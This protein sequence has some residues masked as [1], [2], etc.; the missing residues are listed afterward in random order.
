MSDSGILTEEYVY[1]VAPDGQAVKAAQALLGGEAFD[2][3][4]SADGGRDLRAVCRG[5]APQPYSVHVN[6]ADPNNLRTGCDCSSRK[7]PCKHALALL[8]L[9]INSPHRFERDD[10][11]TAG[12]RSRD[13]EPLTSAAPRK[14]SAEGTA[15]PANLDESL[16]RAILAEPEDDGLR[17]IYADWLEENGRAERAEFIRVQMELARIG[18]A[19][20]RW[21]VLRADEKK[22]WSI[23]RESWLTGLPAHLRKRDIRFHKG[24]LEELAGPPKIWAGCWEELFARHP[25]YRIRVTGAVGRAEAGE[26]AVIPQMGKV[27]VL[28][29]AGGRL[30]EPSKNLAVLFGS[31]FLSG[32][33]RLDLSGGGLT[34]RESA[35]LAG[36][37]ALLG[38]RGLILADNEIGPKGAEWLADIPWREGLNELSLANNPIGDAG[39]KALAG[40][41]HLDALA[42]L[43]LSGVALGLRAKEL[44]R[45][46]FGTRVLLD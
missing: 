22:L 41:A 35:L 2:Q 1:R 34:W 6:L 44:L 10:S 16:Y 13:A 25:I 14:A 40:S 45:E 15:T 24:F 12:R 20:P 32:L 37:P 33:R 3:L 36:S 7:R 5:S 19:G 11:S 46:R 38:L 26:L 39:A 30:V 43:D 4:R 17:L 27:R 21:K 31:P 29:L 23:H 9:A 18:N 42:R 8:L 28:V